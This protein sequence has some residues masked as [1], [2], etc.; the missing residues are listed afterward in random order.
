MLINFFRYLRPG[1]DDP[2][3]GEDEWVMLTSADGFA[4]VIRRKVALTSGTLRNMLSAEG[5]IIHGSDN[6]PVDLT[7]HRRVYG[8]QNQ[9][10]A[11]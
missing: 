11:Y 3:K 9:H 1:Q 4:F 8:G 10:C 2:N 5:A 7:L 6:P